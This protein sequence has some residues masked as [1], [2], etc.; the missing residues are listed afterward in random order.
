MWFFLFFLLLIAK[1]NP[2]LASD[3]SIF[4]LHLSQTSDI[5]SA[6]N[7]INSNGGDWG[8]ITIVLRTDQFNR[9]MWQDFFDNCRL[10]HLTPIIRLATIMEKDYWKRPSFSDVDN[11]INF[12]T[13]LNWPH[14]R[15]YVSLFNEPN[16]GKEWGG[17][18]DAKNY[19]EISIYAAKRLKESNPNFFVLSGGLDLA[20]PQKAPN[21]ESAGSFYQQIHQYKPE[22][23]DLIDALA[24]HSYPNHGFVGLPT[25]NG[26]HSI[27]GYQWELSFLKNLGVKKELPVFITETGWPHREGETRNNSFYTSKTASKL[28]LTALDIWQKDPRVLAVT[29]FIFNF[30]YPPFDHFSWLQKNETIYPEYQIIVDTPKSKNSINQINGVRVKTINL[31]LIIFAGTK[32]ASTLELENTGQA[33]WGET[34]FCLNPSPSPNITLTPLCLDQTRHVLPGHS[35]KISFDFQINTPNLS[36]E[37][38]LSWD[39]L[40]RYNLSPFSPNSRLYHPQ[41]DFWEKIT[42]F[43]QRLFK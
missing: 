22:F 4:G 7:I 8:Y 37:N 9:Q 23:F 26:Q 32:Y 43:F 36:L 2:I 24:S 28:L 31:P 38:F 6:K 3:R 25:D 15:Q 13:S 16:Q 19:A 39:K 11:L 33:I 29:P 35:I 27:R 20:A 17:G 12:L 10:F 30:P 34:T 5:T 1:S 42:Q 18:V 41:S 14:S 21:F 40:P